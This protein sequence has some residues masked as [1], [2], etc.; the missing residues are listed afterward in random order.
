MPTRGQSLV[1]FLDQAEA[2]NHLKTLCVV[3]NPND[4]VALLAEWAAARQRLG[5]STPNAGNPEVLAIPREGAAH[6]QH[7]MQQQW[8]TQAMTA[9]DLQGSQFCLVEIKPLLA[10]QLTVDGK[11]SQ[12]HNGHVQGVPALSDALPICLPHQP[13]QEPLKIFQVPGSMMVTSRSLN[14]QAVAQ[15]YLFNTFIGLQVGVG[16]PFVHVVR[17][18]GRCYLYNG[19]HRVVGL[20]KL[21]ATHVPCVFRDVQQPDQIG[22]KQGTFQLPLLESADPP[23]IAHYVEDR[24]YE[25]E[26]KAFTRTLHVS[27]A[28]YV[29]TT[30]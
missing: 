4:D 18:N 12:H 2:L 30:E 9:P 6:I 11:R 22:I 27:W 8:V 7:L 16:A 25:V 5:A 24:A 21:G 17:Y 20:G 28:D 29:T 23:T 13:A 26:L 14:F 3:N 10:F 19:F 1:G 15:G